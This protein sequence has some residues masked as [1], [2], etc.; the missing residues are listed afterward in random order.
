MSAY[1]LV[2]DYHPFY[3]VR[4]LDL[5][6]SEWTIRV[7]LWMMPQQSGGHLSISPVR[8]QRSE[9]KEQLKRSH[10]CVHFRSPSPSRCVLASGR[11]ARQFLLVLP[12]HRREEAVPARDAHVSHHIFVPIGS[13]IRPLYIEWNLSSDH[14]IS[15]LKSGFK[16]F[17]LW[18]SCQT[19]VY[20]R[21]PEGNENVWSWLDMVLHRCKRETI[22]M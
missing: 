15:T 12:H 7:I 20:F 8:D 16:P 3:T 9:I 18:F 1:A 4:D 19:T 6:M 22:A 17:D 21:S 10:Q 11:L 5:W 13:A 2:V 14:N